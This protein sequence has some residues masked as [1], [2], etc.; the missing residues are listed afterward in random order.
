MYVLKSQLAVHVNEQRYIQQ[1]ATALPACNVITLVY[2]FGIAPVDGVAAL[3]GNPAL[4]TSH[5]P[6]WIVKLIKAMYPAKEDAFSPLH[7]YK[8]LAF[9]L[10]VVSCFFLM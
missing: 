4:R 5:R 8:I 6:P 2:Y 7:I 1:I 10:A 9:M 3:T